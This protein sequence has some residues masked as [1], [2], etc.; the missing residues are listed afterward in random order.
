MPGFLRHRWGN[1]TLRRGA[2]ASL[3]LFAATSCGGDEPV[4]VRPPPPPPPPVA[5]SVSVLPAMVTLAALGETAQLMAQVMDQGGRV[6]PGAAVTWASSDA[7]TATV[8]GAGLVA[9]AGNGTARVTATSGSAAGSATVT[10]SQEVADVRVTPAAGRLHALGD[11][12]RLTAEALDA[13]SHTIPAA[14][15]AWA[16]SD[17]SVVRV[18]EDGLVTAAGTGSGTVTASTGSAAGTATVTV[19][20]QLASVA[21]SPPRANLAEGDSV[22]LY[23]EGRDSRGNEVAGTAFVWT[24]D[25]ASIATVDSTG[26][27][28]ARVKGTARISAT[29]DTVSGTSEITVTLPRVPR[30][31]TV[32]EGTSHSLQ[33][34]GMRI[35]HGRIRRGRNGTSHAVVYADLD[36]DGD[37]DLFYAPLNRTLN[38]LPPE[39]HLSDGTDN[40][41][42]APGFLGPAPPATV[43]ARK[44][45]PGD[46]NGDSRPDIFVLASGFDREPFPGEDNYVLLSSDQGYVP[47]VGLDSIVGYHHGGASADI[48]ADGDL[49]VFVTENFTGPFFLLNDGSGHFRKDTERIR[50]INYRAGIYTAELV[51]VDRDGYVDLLVAGHEYSGFRAQVLWGNE[52]GVYDGAGATALPEAPGNGVVVDIDVA[53]T[54]GDGDRD[55]VLNR[56]GDPGG[57]GFYRGYYVQLLVQTGPRSFVDL[58]TDLFENNQEPE[59]E[60]FDWLRIYDV[61]DDGDHDVVVDDVESFSTQAR[62]DLLWEN[63]GSGG[64]TRMGGIGRPIPPNPRADAGSSHDLQFAGLRVDHGRLRSGRTGW[65]A[66]IAYADFDLDGDIDVFHAP[67][68]QSGEPQP[69]EFHL[70]DGNNEF[71]LGRILTEDSPRVSG[72]RKAVTGD[73]NG[74]G[75]ADILVV[76][77]GQSGGDRE[78]YLILSTAT[79]YRLDSGLEDFAGTYSSV[80]SVD[81]DADGD[82]DV[83]LSG[84]RETLTRVGL[85][86]GEGTFTEWPALERGTGFVLAAEWVDVD[87]D[88]YVDL[89]LGGHEHNGP[90]TR[91]LWGGS[92]GTYRHA[93]ATM[94]PAV[95]GNGVVL[96]IDAGDIDGDGDSDLVITR[97]GDGTGALA[98]YQGYYLQ[99]LEQG[100]ARQFND[101]TSTAL[102]EHRDPEARRSINWVRLYDIDGD[103]DLDILVDDDS[104]RDL[105]WRNDGSGRFERVQGGG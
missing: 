79:G 101:A 18:D 24:S 2:T 88:G 87:R 68:V 13:N 32:D 83:F 94:L 29:A 11:T 78:I 12:L 104:S 4:A 50:N 40:F 48:D 54:D 69:V 10:V 26:L 73:Y 27:V 61:D 93:D 33:T 45:L 99:L 35:P 14:E 30:N 15:F 67:T 70:N 57:A 8:D 49:D 7:S 19:R 103:G 60:W 63:D 89:L 66:A 95:A 39:V 42:F 85:N 9:A 44:A 41:Q 59:A 64:F 28:H 31:P 58:T 77:G 38:P 65:V 5:T 100:G 62:R 21:V 17:T 6:M 46:F 51:D 71:S 96:D 91:I 53:D 56:T 76:G 23:A 97:T 37:T 1:V 36:Q 74:D 102:P 90:G 52:S 22:R 92:T 72:A 75:R 25:D 47:G 84:I 82:L 80:A 98:F 81:L 55:I 86:D 20:Q 105:V 3:V 43:H 16:S 34:T